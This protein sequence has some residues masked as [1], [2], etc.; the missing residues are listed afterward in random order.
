VPERRCKSTAADLSLLKTGASH[1]EKSTNAQNESQAEGLS[2]DTR[3]E[4]LY[5]REREHAR[6]RNV[7]RQARSASHA[8]PGFR[9]VLRNVL[10]TLF[11]AAGAAERNNL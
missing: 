3:P 2:G 8:Y 4:K 7:R 11:A 9:S 10:P 1:D 6:L 5:A